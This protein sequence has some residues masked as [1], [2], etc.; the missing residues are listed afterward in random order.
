[1]DIPTMYRGKGAVRA[2]IEDT[3]DATGRVMDEMALY[4]LL[5]AC[6]KEGVV[7]LVDDATLSDLLMAHSHDRDAFEDDDDIVVWVD[8][9]DKG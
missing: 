9:E 7:Q 3:L 2:K 4:S 8:D 6:F 1:M 5:A